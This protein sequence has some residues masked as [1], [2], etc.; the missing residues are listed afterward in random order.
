VEDSA[1]HERD[2][3]TVVMRRALE[4]DAV[5]GAVV[6]AVVM[7]TERIGYA[8]VAKAARLNL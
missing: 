8:A 3:K 5:V 7:K 1:H 2:A 6:G 4:V